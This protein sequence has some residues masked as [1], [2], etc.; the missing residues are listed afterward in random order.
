M[1]LLVSGIMIARKIMLEEKGKVSLNSLWAS[2][3]HAGMK[4]FLMTRARHHDACRNVSH[5]CLCWN[6]WI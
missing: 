4:A 5:I 2:P 1:H 3:T 6:I